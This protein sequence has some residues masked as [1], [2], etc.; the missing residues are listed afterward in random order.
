MTPTTPDP[1]ALE[2]GICGLTQI[3]GGTEFICINKVHDP[4]YMRRSTDKNHQGV[5]SGTG[6]DPARGRAPYYEYHHFVNRWPY[7]HMDEEKKNG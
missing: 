7:R 2:E 3:V 6:S 5:A 4:E 1:R